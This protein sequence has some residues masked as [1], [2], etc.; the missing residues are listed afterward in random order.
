[1]EAVHAGP[2]VG[3]QLE[4]LQQPGPL[5]GGGDHLQRA[6]LV[7]QQQPGGR[8]AQQLDTSLGERVQ[9][10]DHVEL[11]HQGVGH[12]DEHVR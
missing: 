4:Q 12:L 7:G 9:K 6:V 5:G 10:V 2:L 3:L 1:V 11:V 8:D